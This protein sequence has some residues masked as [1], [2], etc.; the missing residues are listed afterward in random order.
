MGS[1]TALQQALSLL[2]RAPPWLAR[3]GLCGTASVPDKLSLFCSAPRHGWRGVDFA[4]PPRSPT[5]SLSFAPRPAMAGEAW[6]F[7][8]STNTRP[9]WFLDEPTAEGAPVQASA[10]ALSKERSARDDRRV[11][12][13]HRLS[14]MSP[15]GRGPP[16]ARTPQRAARDSIDARSEC[17]KSNQRTARPAPDRSSHRRLCRSRR[18]SPHWHS[19]P[20]CRR[21]QRRRRR[22][23]ES[24]A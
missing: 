2:L 10:S 12:T 23:R 15:G 11:A 22:C 9:G 19:C 5:S 16:A 13:N 7:L 20:A 1:H 8:A 14:W 18:C 4:G 17:L 24:S 21:S 3:R 6:T